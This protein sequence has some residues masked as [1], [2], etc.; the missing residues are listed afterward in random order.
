MLPTGV[1]SG[2]ACSVTSKEIIASFSGES[3][4][5]G[6]KVRRATTW[7]GAYI[8]K[9]RKHFD[10]AI[11]DDSFSFARKTAAIAAEVATDGLYVVR[12][13]LPETTLGDADT[14]RSYKSL[15]RVERRSAASRPSICMCDRFIIGWRDAC[16]RTC[17]CACWPTTS[18]GSCASASHPCCSTTP[19]RM[20]P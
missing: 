7:K 10:L 2:I 15:A 9:M 16:G 8:H 17:F 20:R 14:V 11:T 5:C 3:C 4:E 13:S 12:T 1:L 18:N 19:I 6:G